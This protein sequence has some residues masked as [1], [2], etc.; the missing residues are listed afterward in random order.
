MKKSFASSRQRK[1]ASLNLP[2]LFGCS[3]IG[4][5]NKCSESP[6]AA[7]VALPM[8]ADG[9]DRACPAICLAALALSSCRP[10]KSWSPSRIFDPHPSSC[11]VSQS[12]RDSS[13]RACSECRGAGPCEVE[14]H[15][16]GPGALRKAAAEKAVDGCAGLGIGDH[17]NHPT[18]SLWRVFPVSVLCQL[19]A[20]FGG[21]PRIGQLA[22]R[23]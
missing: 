22:G 14:E 4:L 21:C 7:L 19:Q 6:H 15:G 8:L 9:A 18:L 17:S 13:A 5:Q 11:V 2:V 20:S 23:L 10:A 3:S 16:D 1:V 12:K